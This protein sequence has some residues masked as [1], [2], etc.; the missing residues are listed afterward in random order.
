M[1]DEPSLSY[2]TV[3]W[4]SSAF[5]FLLEFSL[6]PL[7]SFFALF[8]LPWFVP[9]PSLPHPPTQPMP[10]HLFLEWL[11]LFE[12]NPGAFHLSSYLPLVLL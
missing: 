11:I 5:S 4:A 2:L 6:S 12:D 8:Q 1:N 10:G 7:F 3:I 9:A